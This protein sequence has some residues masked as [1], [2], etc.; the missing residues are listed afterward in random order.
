MDTVAR[1][2]PM[3]VP[4]EALWAWHLRPGAI[5]RG[6]APWDRVRVVAEH[7]TENKNDA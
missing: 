6:T 4:L 7:V 2:S 5:E 3:P 1:R